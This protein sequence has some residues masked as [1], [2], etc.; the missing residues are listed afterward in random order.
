[1][2][3][4]LVSIK[5]PLSQKEQLATWECMAWLESNVALTREVEVAAA[6]V[7]AIVVVAEEA[8]QSLLGTTGPAR[9]KEKLDG[10]NKEW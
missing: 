10:G 8:R 7:A 3:C 6:E 4:S 2:R 1:M 5:Y 9:T